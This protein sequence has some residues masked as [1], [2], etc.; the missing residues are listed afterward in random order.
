VTVCAREKNRVFGRDLVE[1]GTGGKLWRFPESLDP[2]A[3]GDPF[4][5]LSLSDALLNFREKIPE[6]VRAFEIQIHLP[7]ADSEDVAMRISQA[8]QN[9]VAVKIDNA[10]SIAAKFVGVFVC[11]DKNN[12]LILDGNR[13]GAW[14]AL[15][16]SIDIP[17][18]KNEIDFCSG[19][20]VLK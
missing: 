1:I 7:L 4:A 12:P 11:A 14:L 18:N 9:S 17:V 20:H 5:A 6:R 16:H 2:A 8:R 10:R 13:F 3:P 19:I 15:V